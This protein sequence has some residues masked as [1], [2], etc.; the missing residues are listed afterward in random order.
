VDIITEIL[1]QKKKLLTEIYFDLQLYFEEKYGKD[2]LVLI[3]IGTFFE[4]YEVN[5][6]H[7]KVGK[8]KEI[9]ELLN[10][11]L[12]RKSK[13]VLENSIS[14]PLLAG[15]PAVSL[16]RYLSRLI[17]TKKYTIIVVKQKGEMLKYQFTLCVKHHISG[18][19]L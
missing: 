16:A 9:A 19:K 10:I 17:A 15:V 5:N 1:S 6:D 4:V 11:Q 8:A 2:A 7:L 12:T 18:Y 13:A 3:E 14:N